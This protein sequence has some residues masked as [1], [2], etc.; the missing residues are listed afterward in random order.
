[1]P[2]AIVGGELGR[3]RWSRILH[4][5]S[6]SVIVAISRRGPPPSG[7]V[8]TSTANT[9]RRSSAQRSLRVLAGLRPRDAPTSLPSAGR[10][11]KG[12]SLVL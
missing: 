2:G 7:Q 4:T 3:P 6:P 9:R 5:T 11:L 1:M 10:R 8:R 12:R